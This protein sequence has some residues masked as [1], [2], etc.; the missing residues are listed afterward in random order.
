MGPFSSVVSWLA[1]GIFLDKHYKPGA[2]YLPGFL[3]KAVKHRLIK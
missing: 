2:A 3:D 1:P